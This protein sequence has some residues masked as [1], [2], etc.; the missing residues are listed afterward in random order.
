MDAVQIPRC[1]GASGI[2][3]NQVAFHGVPV[4]PEDNDAGESG[5]PDDIAVG[6]GRTAND[7]APTCSKQDLGV[8]HVYCTALWGNADEV[9]G[10]LVP[11]SVAQDDAVPAVIGNG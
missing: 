11:G 4:A 5:F 3:P 9:A 7:L 2:S 8:G 1:H 6:R 10:N